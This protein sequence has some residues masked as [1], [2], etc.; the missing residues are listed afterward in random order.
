MNYSLHFEDD[1]YDD[2]DDDD[3]NDVD[4]YNDDYEDLDGDFDVVGDHDGADDADLDL[5]DFDQ[6]LFL[7][8]HM[9][10]SIQAHHHLRTHIIS[11]INTISWHFAN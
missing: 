2:N 7:S 6:N 8:P 10:C 5:G 9:R 4:V 3:D 11:A 1:D